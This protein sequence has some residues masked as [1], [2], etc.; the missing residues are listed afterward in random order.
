MAGIVMLHIDAGAGLGLPSLTALPALAM[1]MGLE[2]AMLNKFLALA[3][4]QR[5][6]KNTNKQIKL[7][8]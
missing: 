8:N 6:Q 7:I 3:V 5:G 4:F 2:A 1:K